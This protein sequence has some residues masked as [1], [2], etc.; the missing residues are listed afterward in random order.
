MICTS[1]F[2]PNNEE[3]RVIG[4]LLNATQPFFQDQ[5][6]DGGDIDRPNV[7]TPSPT[8]TSRAPRS[9]GPTTHSIIIPSSKP[10]RGIDPRIDLR[11]LVLAKQFQNA[12]NIF[13][14][15]A[16]RSY[17]SALDELGIRPR[18]YG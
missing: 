9:V 7:T 2:E 13:L 14:R 8:P 10:H 6:Q 3:R 12:C 11:A 15:G 5:L 4:I 18:Y 1:Q 17:L 16:A